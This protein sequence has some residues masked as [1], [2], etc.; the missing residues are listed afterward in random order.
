VN[1][2]KL[3]E[4][5]ANVSL[6]LGLMGLGAEKIYEALKSACLEERKQAAHV[7]S[8]FTMKPDARIHPD[9]PFSQM[10]DA[11]RIAAHT[12]AQQIAAEI[13]EPELT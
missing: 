2:I 11:S 7:A 5:A 13:L 8:M 12:T 10:N 1:E 6:E 9:I 3:R 4:K